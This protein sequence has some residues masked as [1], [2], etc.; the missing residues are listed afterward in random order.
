[1]AHLPI[2]VKYH[3]L[4]DDYTKLCSSEKATYIMHVICVFYAENDPTLFA[5]FTS[6]FAVRNCYCRYLSYV[7]K[8][9]LATVVRLMIRTTPV[10]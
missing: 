5:W 2:H 9:A 4:V 10:P 1:M 3:I 8:Q 7:Y 6:F